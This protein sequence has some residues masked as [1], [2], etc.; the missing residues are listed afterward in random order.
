MKWKAPVI[1]TAILS[2]AFA[3]PVRSMTVG[4]YASR[5]AEQNITFYIAGVGAGF[6][7]AMNVAKTT[8]QSRLYCPT[9]GPGPSGEFYKHVLDSYL[10]SQGTSI[11]PATSIET[12]LL[13][14][15]MK[16]FPC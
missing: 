9:S 16:Q 5:R 14:I 3:S 13:G 7:Y 10:A 6:Y 12:V 4:D 1:V 11:N 8:G 15:L 2:L